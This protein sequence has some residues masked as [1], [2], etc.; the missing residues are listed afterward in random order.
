M[1]RIKVVGTSFTDAT[2]IFKDIFKKQN[3]KY[4]D[5]KPIMLQFR[6]IFE[7]ENTYD[8]NA[9]RVEAAVP[10]HL[11]WTK[12]GYIPKGTNRNLIKEQLTK[13]LFIGFVVPYQR[14]SNWHFY[15]DV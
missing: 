13:P 1:T 9:V 6:L 7:P 3:L 10:K 5:G 2:A 11:A 4:Q 8:K 14:L 15:F 12:I